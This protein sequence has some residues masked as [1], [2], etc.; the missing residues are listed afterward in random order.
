MRAM[1]E[2]TRSAGRVATL[3]V[4]LFLV[5][6]A[7]VTAHAG[8]GPF[9]LGL[10]IGSP[11]GISGKVYFNKQNALDFAIGAAF[12]NQRGFHIHA[13]YLWHPVMLTQDDAF[14]LPL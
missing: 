11:T 7:P 3:A 4:L 10:I 9:G 6:V 5:W 1:T 12:V 2:S 8:G 14:F 13:D